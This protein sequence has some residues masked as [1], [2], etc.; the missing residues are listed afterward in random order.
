M[1]TRDFYEALGVD[2][3]ASS[4]EIRKAYRRLAREHHPDRNPDNPKAEERFKEVTNA[5]EVL[6]D[7]E[8]RQ[9]YDDLGMEA[10]AIDFDPEKART[11]KQWAEQQTRGG[12]YGGGFGRPSGGG[13]KGGFGGSG[14]PDLGDLFGDLFRGG[15]SGFDERASRGPHPGA[16]IRTR[17]QVSFRDAALGAERRISLDRPG[18]A[19]PC[20]RCGGSGRVQAQQGGLQL[21]V[22]CPACGG[23]GVTAGPSER[24]TLDVKIPA[25]V[26]DGQTI[27]LKGQGAPGGRGGPRGDLLIELSVGSHPTLRRE[28]K[29][30]HLD[31][32][33]TVGEAMLGGTIEI[34][35]LT[36]KVKLTVPPG[37]KAGQKLRLRGK[38]VKDARSGT[39]GDLYAHLMVSLPPGADPNDPELR[40]AVERI[41]RLYRGSPRDD[42]EV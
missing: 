42:L 37:V 32:P 30:L 15:F 21:A 31:I 14:G 12:G 19:Q 10:E 40:S 27:R 8:K 23:E 26:E 33:L 34:P 5:Y 4:D 17:M 1:A 7:P 25:G 41:E 20:P 38:G 22:P 28:G 18:P 2:R 11:Y 29:D 24:T 9:V 35:T 16:D 36:G 39:S 3:T 13:G 6:S